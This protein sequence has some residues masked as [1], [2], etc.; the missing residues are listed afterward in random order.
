MTTIVNLSPLRQ[1]SM[2][3]PV[4][5]KTLQAK[6]QAAREKSRHHY[7][8]GDILQR[9]KDLRTCIKK[10]DKEQEAITKEISRAVKKLHGCDDDES[11]PD[12][13]STDD[14]SDTLSDLP[15]CLLAI[16]NAK[17]DMLKL[18]GADPCEFVK[19]ELTKYVESIP[20]DCKTRGDISII[21]NSVAEIEK[22][23]K[24]VLSLH[25]TRF[26]IPA[27]S[28]LSGTLQTQSHDS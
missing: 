1:V 16:K 21:E 27:E 13:D 4:V 12:D 25:K 5:H 9:R 14:E 26:S 20:D 2:V 10:R 23:L 7:S 19:G 28:H 24:H 17:D 18:I 15:S 8:K 3:R 22:L 11:E 6:M